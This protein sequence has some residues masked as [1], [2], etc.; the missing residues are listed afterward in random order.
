MW[1][2]TR[3]LTGK[4]IRIIVTNGQGLAQSALM[5]LLLIFVFSLAQDSSQPID[6]QWAAA[7]FWLATSFSLVLIFNTLY[8]LEEDNEARLGL[9]LSP[10]PAQGVWLAK[11]LA[12]WLLLLLVQGLFLPASVIFLGIEQI[13]SWSQA[14]ALLLIV[15]WGLVVLGS[16]LGALGQGQSGRDS[17]LTVI[18][19]PLLIPLLLT[20]IRVGGGL[21][22]GEPVAAL[23]SW[24]GLAGAFDAL[25]TGAALLLFPFV[26]SKAE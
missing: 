4:D 6:P 13:G 20:G 12:G 11:A 23:S 25:F 16:L 18:V 26:Y 21:L 9:I 7:I 14:L 15:D 24:F 8:G 17:L 19:F 22:T 1:S 2:R 3:I 5:G 10:L